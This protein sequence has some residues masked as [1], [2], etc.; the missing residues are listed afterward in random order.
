MK[1]E[2]TTDGGGANTLFIFCVDTVA[3]ND[4]ATFDS[5][6]Y[7]GI[8]VTHWLEDADDTEARVEKMFD[9]LF[10]EVVRRREEGASLLLE[11]YE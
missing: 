8:H 5:T 2:K 7:R 1:Y 11:K 10:D 3:V 9:V 6:L 4:K